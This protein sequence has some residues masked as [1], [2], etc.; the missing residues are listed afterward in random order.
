MKK[1]PEKGDV[2]KT[3]DEE[4]W[5]IFTAPKKALFYRQFKGQFALKDLRDVSAQE[6]SEFTL[7]LER[8]AKGVP[9]Q[10]VD[11][12]ECIRLL[13]GLGPFPFSKNA[14]VKPA[15]PSPTVPLRPQSSST[16]PAPPSSYP[17]HV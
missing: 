2:F 3:S 16:P 8:D 4:E 7:A 6:V 17:Q 11:A 1:I 12:F 10:V 5:C 14:G 13:I 9:I 15:L